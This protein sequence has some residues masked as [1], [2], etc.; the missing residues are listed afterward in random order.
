VG[1]SD[2]AT[3]GT[4]FG[5]M[6]LI[7]DQW[8]V[9][10][11]D[12][13]GP[14]TVKVM[15]PTGTVLYQFDA[16][17]PSFTGGVRVATGD[18]NGDAVPDLFCAP[19]P[20]GAPLVRVFDGLTQA[21]IQEIPVFTPAFT[22]GVNLALGDVHS[23]AGQELVVA[24][25]TGAPSVLVYS[26]STGQLVTKFQAFGPLATTGLR[27]SI[28]DVVASGF[29]EVIVTRRTGSAAVRVWDANAASLAKVILVPGQSTGGLFLA[30]GDF[31]DAGRDDLLIGRGAGSLPI[32]SLVESDTSSEFNQLLPFPTSYTGG[33]RVAAVDIDNDGRSDAI[34]A[35]GKNAPPE[36]TVIDP[37][38]GLRFTTFLAF[39]ASMTAGLFVVAALR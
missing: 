34:M 7:R 17:D 20:G 39:D 14:P 26:V 11:A 27:V 38:T 36:I 31:N 30:V 1:E 5:V 9:V 2:Q 19:G 6:R 12:R 25:H 15:T 22:G 10:S 16:F 33:V 4:D 24:R 29:R 3:S 23:S 13:G 18:A 21:L 32:V 35:K 37:D 28:A 8:V